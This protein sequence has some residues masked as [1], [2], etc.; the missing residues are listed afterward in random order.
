MEAVTDPAA[1][2]AALPEIVVA[3]VALSVQVVNPLAERQFRQAQHLMVNLVARLVLLA[4][5]LTRL[6]LVAV[7]VA[8]LLLIAQELGD[9]PTK[10]A[11]AAA[12]AEVI[13]AVRLPQ[14]KLGVV[15]PEPPEVVELVELA[16]QAQT[17]QP[18]RLDQVVKAAVVVVVLLRHLA[19]V[20]VQPAGL[21][22]VVAAA[23]AAD[24]TKSDHLMALVA[25]VALDV[26][27][28]IR[29]KE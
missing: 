21:G 17:E 28:S 12:A 20:M 29:G 5:Q 10:E 18:A 3:V 15:L 19:V 27:V 8:A 9:V 26:A 4:Q 11:L 16:D 1:K 2:Q 13:T 22:V 23:V 6:V 7:A 24:L 25:L 14:G